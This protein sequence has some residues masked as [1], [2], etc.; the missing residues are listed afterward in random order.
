MKIFK[1]FVSVVGIFCVVH[2]VYGKYEKVSSHGSFPIRYFL[3][4]CL[5]LYLLAKDFRRVPRQNARVSKN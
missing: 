5:Q 2:Y 3:C 4:D 1:N